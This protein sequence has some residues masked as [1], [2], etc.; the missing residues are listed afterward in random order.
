MRKKRILY[1]LPGFIT[2]LF[3][4]NLPAKKEG[5]PVI[6]LTF[7]DGPDEIVTPLILTVLNKYEIKGTFFCLGEKAEKLPYLLDLILESKHNI[8]NHSYSHKSGWKTPASQYYNDVIKASG[9]LKTKLFRPPYGKIT[10]QQ[11]MKLKSKFQFIFWNILSADYNSS[12]TDEE[13]CN[14]ILPKVKPGHII[15]FHD[16]QIEGRNLTWIIEQFIVNLKK[17]NYQFDKII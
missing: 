6:Y 2:R 13:I 10:L 7:D 12:F 1:Q 9:L 16:R 8:G 4:K 17:Q 3:Y 15:V 14:A 5:K 11:W